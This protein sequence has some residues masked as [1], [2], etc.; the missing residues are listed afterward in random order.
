MLGNRSKSPR[1]TRTRT[2]HS[3][4]LNAPTATPVHGSCRLRSRSVLV[5]VTRVEWTGFKVVFYATPTFV[6]APFAP[7]F[8]REGIPSSA[9][10][11]SP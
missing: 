6:F 3:D 4:A 2:D 7:H 5:R 8:R 10:S 1:I 11:I 9:R